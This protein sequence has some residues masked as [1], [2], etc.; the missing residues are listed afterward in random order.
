M[1]LTDLAIKYSSDKYYKHSYIP[2]YEKLFAGFTPKR[3]LEIGIGYPELMQRQLPA[4]VEWKS[5][6]SL[7]MWAELWPDAEITG[8]DIREDVCI[9]EGNIRSLVVDQSSAASLMKLYEYGPFDLII[10]DGSH[11]QYDQL[12]TSHIL[13]PWLTYAGVYVIEDVL[14][15][16]GISLAATCGGLYLNLGR[17]Y[18]DNMVVIPGRDYPRYTREDFI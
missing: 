9:N 1:N 7:H 18:D 5:A 15:T 13:L 4:D 2:V 16:H 3:V 11:R 8:V 14:P 12:L 10:D 6:S 17:C